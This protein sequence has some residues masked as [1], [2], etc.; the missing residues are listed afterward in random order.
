MEFPRQGQVLVP[1]NATGRGEQ[2]ERDRFGFKG[3]CTY[4]T[5][6]RAVVDAVAA[7][8]KDD[9]LGVLVDAQVLRTLDEAIG[10]ARAG[11]PQLG[12]GIERSLAR[13]ARL[14]WAGN[15]VP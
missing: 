2:P 12:A 11:N 15:S 14:G 1:G 8:R 10:S 5:A 13:L 3:E 6:A 7:G 4:V 9:A